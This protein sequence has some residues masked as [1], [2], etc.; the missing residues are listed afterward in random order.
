MQQFTADEGFVSSRLNDVNAR[1]LLEAFASSYSSMIFIDLASDEIL[2]LKLSSFF[3][4]DIRTAILNR[5]PIQVMKDV[6]SRY[7]DPEGRKI[8]SECFEL[9]GV[10]KLLGDKNEYSFV[11]HVN[12]SNELHHYKIHINRSF[13]CPTAFLYGTRCVDREIQR[14]EMLAHINNMLCAMA[15]EYT[16]LY[17]TL[18]GSESFV[19]YSTTKRISAV[20]NHQFKGLTTDQGLAIYVNNCVKDVDKESMRA[21][22]TVSNLLKLVKKHRVV[23]RIYLNEQDRY[24]EVKCALASAEE[25]TF[26]IG[27]AVKD[28]EIRNELNQQRIISQMLQVLS[29]ESSPEK[30]ISQL[31]EALVQYYRADRAYYYEV[32]HGRTCVRCSYQYLDPN[33]PEE[34]H[35]LAPEP[36]ENLDNWAANAKV[37]DAYYIACDDPETEK[38]PAALDLLRRRKVSNMFSV[39]SIRE[40]RVKGFLGVD[41]VRL[42]SDDQKTIKLIASLIELELLRRQLSDEET[43]VFDKLK[44]SFDAVYYADFL[45]DR[46]TTYI[47]SDRYRAKYGTVYSYSKSKQQYIDQDIAEEDRAMCHIQMAPDYVMLQLKN[48][49]RFSVHYAELIDGVRRNC[50]MQFIR[51]NPEGTCAVFVVIDNTEAF[52]HEL[53]IQNELKIAKHQAEMASRA[54]STFLFNMSHD[55]RTPLNAIKGFT[56]LAK[57]HHENQLRLNDYLDKI[58]ASSEHLIKLINDILDMARIESG[59]VTISRIPVDL[60][61]SSRQI[62][63]MIQNMAA[64]KDITFTFD[65]SRLQ[66]IDVYTDPLH[67][68]QVLLNILS[69]A[70]KYTRPKGH[71]DYSI[72]QFEIDH[73]GAALYK[74]TV[75]DDGVGMSEDFLQH[76]YDQFTRAKSSTESGITGTGLG[77]S[78]V[79]NLVNLMGGEISIRSELNKGTTVEIDIQFEVIDDAVRASISDSQV[80]IDASLVG[81]TILVVEDNALNREIAVELLEDSGFEVDTAENG[82]EALDKIAASAPGEYDV[83]LMDIQMPVMDGYTAT[84]K[85]RQ[86]KLDHQSKLPIIAMTANA[87][88]EDKM[89]AIAAGMNGHLSK[90][91]NIE[92]TIATIKRHLRKKKL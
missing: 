10:N 79:K 70:V 64:D 7:A 27:F 56:E 26:V 65:T 2:L 84:E 71:V 77:M 39:P 13:S 69:N 5:S 62:L 87:F 61:Q 51:A 40:G 28:E 15:Q 76:I 43:I 29:E 35:I 3:D 21:F 6:L 31:L 14:E 60:L 1:G 38:E 73:K 30:A 20:F 72:E 32:D 48:N 75:K 47:S 63:P 53:E 19:S 92:A 59:A 25:N 42:S 23:T 78:I 46:S 85:I 67:L 80:L 44:K 50:E 24:C 12:H 4:P 11:M 66:N 22:L 41:N 86:L 88:E 34:L 55:I 68:N 89:R 54:K 82:Q 37:Q 16:D 17:Y 52:M 74:F 9:D 91:I 8:L 81:V 90:P 45:A 83:V 33:C 58:E 49:E 36:I 57:R 18:P